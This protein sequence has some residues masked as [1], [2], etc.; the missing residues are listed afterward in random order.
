MVRRR[1]WLLLQRHPPHRNR[2]GSRTVSLSRPE[3]RSVLDDSPTDSLSFRSLS[4]CILSSSY[5]RLQVVLAKDPQ[6]PTLRDLKQEISTLTS[7]PY[8]QIK[9]VFSGMVMKEDRAP[10]PRYG[11]RD[12]S[13]VMLIGTAGGASSGGPDRNPQADTIGSKTRPAGGADEVEQRAEASRQ[14][15]QQ[16]ARLKKQREEDQSESGLLKRIQEAVAGVESD[17][18]PQIEH[19]EKS[20][21]ALTSQSVAASAAANTQAVPAAHTSSG[22]P[23]TE[24]PSQQQSDQPPL[25]QPLLTPPQIAFDQRKLSELL[26]RSLLTL[27][28]IQVNSETTRTSRKAA[29]KRVQSLLDRVDSAWTRA[30]E[31][32]VRAGT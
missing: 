26:L 32:G 10:L 22:A 12:G 20:V 1:V 16:A 28:G 15:Q 8:D 14:A 5:V 19:L 18:F 11:L 21:A 24:Q 9:L 29:V 30:K 31:L 25:E 17:L 6:P 23:S 7:I 13:R 4:A 27:D 2:L 3:Q